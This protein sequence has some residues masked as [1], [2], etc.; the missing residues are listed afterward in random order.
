[1]KCLKQ[2]FSGSSNIYET[3]VPFYYSLKFFGLASFHFNVEDGKIMMRWKDYFFLIASVLFGV[4]VICS[5]CSEINGHIEK[6]SSFIQTGWRYQYVY[7]MAII[8]PIIIFGCIKIK[9]VERFLEIIYSFDE[10]IELLN[11][12]HKVNHSKNKKHLS[13]LIISSALLI[14]MMYISSIFTTKEN[15]ITGYI[16]M[17]MSMIVIKFH[18]FVTYQ[19]TFSVV[20]IKDRYE[21]LNKNMR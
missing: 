4:V 20:S 19:F 15:T 16:F 21:I 3:A 18:H 1:M 14:I 10:F 6:G 11:W 13:I 7:Q 5:S 17:L 12:E 2:I 8:I 9:H